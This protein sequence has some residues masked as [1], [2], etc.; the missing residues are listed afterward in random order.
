MKP[1]PA[2]LS[3]KL[4]RAVS[5][6]G[7]NWV[8]EDYAGLD[9]LLCRRVHDGYRS[10]LPISELNPAIG[11]D[12]ADDLDS[13]TVSK[14]RKQ[15]RAR[16]L[17]EIPPDAELSR[18]EEHRVAEAVDHFQDALA[19]RAE[20]V[21]RVRRQMTEAFAE[22]FGVSRATAYRKVQYAAYYGTTA[23][24]L[25]ARRS[26]ANVSRHPP[27]T[28]RLLDVALAELRFVPEKRTVP[29]IK[30]LLDGRLKAAGLPKI[31]ETV[32]YKRIAAKT[33][34]DQLL[35]EGRKKEAENSYGM[36]VGHLPG[37]DYP[38][39]IVQA[40]HS[41]CQVCFV[42]SEKRL[43]VG[44]AWL[45]TI[46]D[47]FSRMLLGFYVS[48]GAP[49]TLNFGLALARAFLPKEEFLEKMNVQGEW[50]CW[51]IP[52]LIHTDN[53]AELTGHM[54]QRARRRYRITLRRRP[55]ATPQLGS[56]VESAFHTYLREHT[57]IEGTKFRNFQQKAQ[58]DPAG[59][60]MLTLDEFEQLFTEYIVNDYHLREHSGEGM[61]RRSPLQRWKAGLFDGDSG[62]IARGWPDKPV[63][64]EKLRISLMPVAPNR[65]IRKG[66]ISVQGNTYFSHDLADLGERTNV[67]GPKKG[68]SFDVRYDPRELSTVWVERGPDSDFIRAQFADIT[69][70]P[71]SLWEQKTRNKAIGR[72][73]EV[74]DDQ[75]SES[76]TKR[77]AL[78]Q[79]AKKKTEKARRAAE[80]TKRDQLDRVISV[81][82]PPRSTSKPMKPLT[83]EDKQKLARKLP[84]PT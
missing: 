46:I 20:P 53:G 76:A 25:R 5:H 29:Q 73:A 42:D 23:A 6:G 26:D 2:S 77:E 21:A 33:H 50:P 18:P 45:T 63:D 43:P 27:E 48:F 31:S 24:M 35:L 66:T 47:C 54:M 11:V 59:H 69:K 75:R 65:I 74:Y 70:A 72:P 58:Y 62:R 34:R 71:R 67:K 79:D 30:S 17:R 41:R 81:P 16:Q 80:R 1:A 15:M 68:R 38:M 56:H 55:V 12:D 39:A 4:G 14:W 36:K 61:Q 19:I 3:L 7:A 57:T 82:S 32:I 13:G 83:A 52:D 28:W 78:K 8:I 64:P 22:K 9:R 44:D 60:A 49:S 84:P 51:G 37:A 10:F 40:D